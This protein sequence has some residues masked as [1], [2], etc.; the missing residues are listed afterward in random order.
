MDSPLENN[1]KTMLKNYSVAFLSFNTVRQ[2]HAV[3]PGCFAG[4]FRVLVQ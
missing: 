2:R 3:G 4:L 1:F